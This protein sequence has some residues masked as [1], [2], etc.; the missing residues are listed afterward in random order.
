MIKNNFII[1]DIEKYLYNKKNILIKTRFAPEPNGY[2]HLGHVKTIF[3]NFFIAKKY[4][5]IF[6]LRFDDTNPSNININYIKNIKND[7]K[8]LG[9]KWDG[10][11]KYSSN[12]FLKIFKFAIYLINKG[13]A[14]I[15][16]LPLYIMNK[17]K[18]SFNKYGVN[19][20]YRNRSIEEN[21]YLFNKMKNGFFKENE[22]C[23][24]AKINMNSSI[25]SMR[26]PVLYRIR[27]KSHIRTKN[28][29]CI[30]PTYDF[31]NCISDYIEKITHS[32]CT[33]EFINNKLLY[34]WIIHNICKNDDIVPIQYE[35]SKL[36]L[37]YNV[38]SKSKLKKI[39]NNNTISGWNDPR[40]LT[41]SGLKN[42]GYTSNSI[43]DFCNKLGITKKNSVIKL[44]LLESCI[45]SD[46]DNK[47]FRLMA[48]LEPISLYIKNLKD[49]YKNILEIYN[50]PNDKNLGKRKILFNNKIFIEKSDVIK[51]IY[52]EELDF[53]FNKIIKL[54]YS[55]T[56]KI[57]KVNKKYD[58]SIDNIICECYL[59]SLNSI[60]FN[61]K[62][63]NIII[64]WVS[65]LVNSKSKFF[66]YK[67]LFNHKHPYLLK[68]YNKYINKHS[69]LIKE[70]YIEK[71][72]KNIFYKYKKMKSFQLERIGYFYI[73]KKSKHNN[74][75][76]NEIINLKNNNI[77]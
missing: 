4:N 24:R 20:P 26:D 21:I 69:I 46:L 52:N 40:I 10:K 14:Y 35:F 48:I 6:N 51:Y 36:N 60:F 7:I 53:I 74:I 42:K 73:N 13:L 37:E 34:N 16:E 56:I 67:N 76:L 11:V 57:L 29:W 30:Y 18:G 9:F 45:R 41:I 17:Y 19:S 63:I 59:D 2:L 77:T 22:V 1:K 58:N 70:G 66:I 68:N 25:I 23:L 15:D 33:I 64:H 47:S 44:S 32:L 31:A 49:S 28:N 8:W 5:G 65:S 72:N 43:L 62:K 61:K 27:F 55:Y 50:H 71:L 39:I 75:I 38:L 3:I 12:Y 54:K